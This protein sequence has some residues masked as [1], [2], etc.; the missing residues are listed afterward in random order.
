MT[1][2]ELKKLCENEI[3]NGRGDSEIVVC[4]YDDTYQSLERSFS[5]PVYNACGCT[6]YI[7]DND[8]D[9]ENTLI[10]N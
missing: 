3:A 10:L 5:S 7:E 6:E 9:A 4:C 8:L 1:I 2:N